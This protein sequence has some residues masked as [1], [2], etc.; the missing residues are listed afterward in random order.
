MN[1]HTVII[2]C[3]G[4]VIPDLCRLEACVDAILKNP[5][6]EYFGRNGRRLYSN[7]KAIMEN[8]NGKFFIRFSF[9][10]LLQLDSSHALAVI[11]AALKMNMVKRIN[12]DGDGIDVV[13]P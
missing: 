8:L 2:K 12:K 10:H 9:K 11:K 13:L 3:Q 5:N 6:I 4:T 7:P 1:T